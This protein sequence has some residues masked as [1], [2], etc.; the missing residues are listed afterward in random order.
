MIIKPASRSLW[1]YQELMHFLVKK[2]AIMN[3]STL[4]KCILMLVLGS[5][6]HISWIIWKVYILLNPE[7]WIWVD[8]HLIYTQIVMNCISLSLFILMIYI[9]HRWAKKA[10]IQRYLPYFAVGVLVVSL[11]RDGYLVGVFSPAT[12]ISYVCLVTVG[13]VLFNRVIVYAA[14]IPATLFL[15]AAGILGFFN[16]IPYGPL[17]YFHG[18]TPYENGFWILSMLFFISPMMLTCLVLFE[19]LL[20]QWRYRE[21]L[22]RRLS[23]LDPL[24]NLFN[25]RSINRYLHQFD[26]N[27]DK[28]YAIILIDLDH[29]KSINDRFGHH[30]GDEALVL[31]AKS[32]ALHVRESDVVGRFGGEEFILL[33]KNTEQAQAVNI[34]ERCLKSIEKIELYTDQ[35]QAIAM[36]ASFG[37]AISDPSIRPQQLL[38]NADQA[39]Y[40]AKA[41]GRNCIRCYADV[42]LSA[43]EM[44]ASELGN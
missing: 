23:Q 11:C 22:I 15:F 3:W 18:M 1:S 16:H 36:T 40:A 38:T 35:Q 17:F 26:L 14:M 21:Q 10:Y 9:C 30:K 43:S 5:L 31:V 24:T 4:N 13:L 27:Q 7:V 34:A 6:I 37:I 39:L 29:F 42:N 41:A 8:M 20:S 32:L 25:R 12:M 28:S 19:I 44:L 33:L 2:S